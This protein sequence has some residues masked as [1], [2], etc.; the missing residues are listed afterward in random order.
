VQ[1]V[2]TAG[3]VASGVTL[4]T[5]RRNKITG[6]VIQF[7][8]SLAMSAAGNAAN[9]TVH[10]LSLGRRMKHG[11]RAVNVGHGVG[12]SSAQYDPVAHTATL[13]FG[14]TL[15][16]GQ[17]FQLRVNGGSGG[18]TDPANH[19]LNSSS[20]GAP[21]SDSVFTANQRAI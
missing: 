15:R 5:G 4:Q 20:Q 19:P 7:N 1:V 9:Y 14:S 16:A 2:N 11:L 6:L 10:V 13:A 18:I 12:V 17:M 8:T 21:G 3:P